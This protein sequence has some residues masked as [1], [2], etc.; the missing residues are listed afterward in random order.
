MT[1]QLNGDYQARNER[2]AAYLVHAKQ[3]LSQ[4]E[5][6]EVKQIGR[7][8]NSHTDHLANPAS[9]VEAGNKRTVE[10]ET[11]EKPSIELQPPRQVMCVDLSPSWMDPIIAYLRD[12]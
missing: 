3:L 9:A 2:V 10:V 11:L 5:R 7:D 8:S 12:D 6:V 1:S 4:F